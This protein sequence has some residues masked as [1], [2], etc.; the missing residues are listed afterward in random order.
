MPITEPSGQ[1]VWSP[2]IR[3]QSVVRKF[4]G[5]NGRGYTAISIQDGIPGPTSATGSGNVDPDA[6]TIHLQVWF[7]DVSDQFSTAPGA[8][9][10]DVDSTVITREDKGLYYY[11]LGPALTANR[12]ILTLKWTYAIGGTQFTY[13]DFAQILGQM[14][15]YDSLNEQEQSIIEQV[16]WMFGDLFDSTEGGPQLIEPFQTDYT[17]ERLA[18]LQVLAVQ[19]FNMMYNFYNPPT[20]YG[21]GPGTQT[22]P[23]QFAGLMVFGLYLEV[24]R[25]LIRSYV[26]IPDFSGADVTYTNRRDYFDRWNSVYQSEWPDYKLMVKAAKISLLNMSRGALL[27]GGGIYGG[28]ALGIFQ[29]GTYASQVRSWRFYPAAPAISWGATNH[30]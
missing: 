2:K 1:Q 15:L 20:T 4:I 11:E 14:G 18:Q 26:E 30:A 13:M 22:L 25:H 17:Y 10:A 23:A 3:D 29:A 7:Q 12:G 8:L 28:N 9:I 16:T 27:V 6:G 19:R 5:Q 21:V 24:L